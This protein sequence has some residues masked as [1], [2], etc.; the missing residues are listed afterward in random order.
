MPGMTPEPMNDPGW[1]PGSGRDPASAGP[2]EVPD[3]L[4]EL[5]VP[6]SADATQAWWMDLLGTI[7]QLDR[8]KAA[9]KEGDDPYGHLDR[10]QAL[11]TAASGPA[12][13]STQLDWLHDELYRLWVSKKNERRA[14]IDESLKSLSSTE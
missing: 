6:V 14:A 4:V 12:L 11:V 13:N 8:Y 1:A 2:L 7:R 9:W 10:L 5:V 3:G